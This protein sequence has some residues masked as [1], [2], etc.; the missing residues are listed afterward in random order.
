MPNQ[1]IPVKDANAMVEQ[2][3]IYM[4]NHGIDP[5]KQ[6]HN[7]GF[8]T[9]NLIEWLNRVKDLTDEFRICLGVY[10]AGHLNAGRLTTIIWPYKDGKPARK[11]IQG[12]DGDDTFEDPYN[13][14]ELRP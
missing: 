14:G 9:P 3:L 12:K 4:T 7:V 1:T 8:T 6:T 10:P 5:L 11:P 13:E 2:Y